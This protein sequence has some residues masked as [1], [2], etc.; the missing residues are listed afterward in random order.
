MHVPHRVIRPHGTTQ[1]TQTEWLSQATIPTRH[2]QFQTHVFRDVRTPDDGGPALSQEHVA[3]VFGDAAGLRGRQDVLVR[4]H[5]ECIT[6]EV[7]GSLKCDCK[8]QFDRAMASVARAG[9]GA[10]LYLRQE[11]RGIGLANKIRA[12]ELQSLGH[13]TVEANRMLGLP[14][15]ARRYDVAADMLAHFGIE[16][17]KLLTNNPAKVTAL[18]QL[19]VRVVGRVPI[20]VA[21]NPHS[22]RYLEVKRVRMEH[23]LPSELLAASGD[24]E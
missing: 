11:G 13:D 17:V 4:V 9:A 19:G 6:S 10:V 8:E 2:G 15:D 24:A 23:D 5:S 12:Y 22:A 1:S 7:F 3:L 16:S 14:I 21:A 20:V 18:R